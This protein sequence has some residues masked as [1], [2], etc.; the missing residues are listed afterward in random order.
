MNPKM[1]TFDW[2]VYVMMGVE[3]WDCTLQV[4]QSFISEVMIV[5][6]KSR[7]WNNLTFLNCFVC[8]RSIWKH[9]TCSSAYRTFFKMRKIDIQQYA[10]ARWGI[11]NMNRT[12]MSQLHLKKFPPFPFGWILLNLYITII[13]RVTFHCTVSSAQRTSIGSCYIIDRWHLLWAHKAY[14]T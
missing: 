8:H 3:L 10:W 9:E 7:D 2:I 1:S 4:K 11:I 13:F 12:Y 5:N 6:N 14:E